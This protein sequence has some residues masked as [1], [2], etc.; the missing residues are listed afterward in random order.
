[1]KK[2]LS[3]AYACACVDGYASGQ[4]AY[5]EIVPQFADLC[6]R[7]SLVV[8]LP[9]GAG[10]CEVDVDECASDP[11]QN[12]QPCL[13]SGLDVIVPISEAVRL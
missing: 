9:A 11:C 10:N 3:G 12:Q 7:S 8:G 5:D 4:C 13:E 6:D 1:M 2:I